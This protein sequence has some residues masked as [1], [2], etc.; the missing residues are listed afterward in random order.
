MDRPP[1]AILQ[2]GSG[3]GALERL[4]REATGEP[5]FCSKAQVFDE[6][7]LGEAQTPWLAL[8]NDGA[9]PHPLY[10]MRVLPALYGGSQHSTFVRRLEPRDDVPDHG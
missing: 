1:E 5:S 7:S 4:H 6:A 10:E 9:V 8:L 3:W 2:R